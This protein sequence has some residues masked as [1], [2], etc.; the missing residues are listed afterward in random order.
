MAP[1][2]P[3]RERSA[4]N[5]QALRSLLSTIPGV[6]HACDL[7][8]LLFFRRHPL[9]LLTSEQLVAYLG[10]E[11]D[12]VATSLD[13]LIDAG[14]LTRSQNPAHAARLFELELRGSTG[15][16]LAFLLKIAGTREGRR[17]VLQMLDSGPGSVPTARAR[18]SASVARIAKAA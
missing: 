5:E 4:V 9:A 2:A 12:R 18:R 3:R 7:D 16:Q 13:G 11:R 6:R 17:S 1:P 14:L 15:G 8:L 10:Y